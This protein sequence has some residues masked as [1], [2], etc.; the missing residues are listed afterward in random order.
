LH[1]ADID[2]VRYRDGSVGDGRTTVTFAE[3]LT[4]TDTGRIEAVETRGQGDETTRHAFASFGACFA[5]VRVNRWTREPRVARVTCVVDAGTIVNTKA[6]R[7]QI[8]GGIVWGIG[9]AL[10]EGARTDAATGRIANANLADYPIPVNADVPA[11]DV[12]F[13]DH[14]DTAFNPL[15]ARGIGELG[16]TGSAAAVANAVHNATGIRVR[17]LPITVDKL[18]DG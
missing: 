3:L 10:L 13:L 12:H 18:L 7:N 5:E 4:A 8:A 16:T 15:G 17:D 6:A 11:V 14:P 1:G 9:Q 2:A